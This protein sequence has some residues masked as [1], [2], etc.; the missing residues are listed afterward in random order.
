MKVAIALAIGVL[1]AATAVSDEVRLRGG[2]RLVGIV[3]EDTP[4]NVV[5]EVGAGRVTVPRSLVGSISRGHS[6]LLTYLSRADALRRDDVAGWLELAAW[7]EGNDLK[8]QAR[9]AYT[10]VVG[11]DSQNAVANRALG[12]LMVGSQWMTHDE[13]MPARGYVSFEGEWLTPV[14]RDAR[15]AER[16]AQRREQLALEHERATR[17]ES[18]ARVREAEARARE[19]EASARI[20]EARARRAEE[21]SIWG[22]SAYPDHHRRPRR[23]R[24]GYYDVDYYEVG[25]TVAPPQRPSPIVHPADPPVVVVPAGPAPGTRRRDKKP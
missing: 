25:Y 7:A 16:E 9:E 10:H 18:E 12:H 15:L 1:A 4:E 17:I 5:V 22:R 3:V 14:E 21:R 11:I 20:E 24:R 23:P 19:A 13:A 8:T 2:G 6:A